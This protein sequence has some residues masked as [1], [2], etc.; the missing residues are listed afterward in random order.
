MFTKILSIR[1]GFPFENQLE[2]IFIQRYASYFQNK[3]G[4]GSKLGITPRLFFCANLG[5]SVLTKGTSSV[6]FKVTNIPG[7]EVGFI[8]SLIRTSP[9]VP[10][11]LII[12]LGSSFS[13][14]CRRSCPGTGSSTP[15]LWEESM[16]LGSETPAAANN[17]MKVHPK[18]L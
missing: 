10:A 7:V 9:G 3:P 12:T 8:K 17:L 14:G 6:G 2:Q 1:G 5:I 4:I 16:E 13:I 15:L 18:E 11:K